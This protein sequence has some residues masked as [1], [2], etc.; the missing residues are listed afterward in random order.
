[1]DLV[2]VWENYGFDGILFILLIILT[3]ATWKYLRHLKKDL[4]G[5]IDKK[6]EILKD[7]GGQVDRMHDTCHIPVGAMNKLESRMDVAEH[8]STKFQIDV[9]KIATTLEGVAVQ[10]SAIYNH[11]FNE[12]IKE[13][14]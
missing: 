9:T 1:M 8:E 6:A 7:L 5:R 10:T 4:H 11:Y 13:K 14:R 3:R 12:G 2:Y